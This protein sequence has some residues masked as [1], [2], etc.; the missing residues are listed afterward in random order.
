MI[1]LFSRSISIT[2]ILLILS[3]PV[4]AGAITILLFDRNFNTSNGR[5][6]SNFIST[7]ILIFWS[8]RSLYFNFTWVWR[9]KRNIFGNLRIIYAILGIG[10]L[11]LTG[12]ILSNSSI[13]IILHDSYYVVGH[14]HY[15]LSIAA[16]FSIIAR[17]IH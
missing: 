4:L 1:K 9:K 10:F 11:E 3:L 13:D 8:S 7:F 6:R 15:V 16:V 17:F 2:V 5:R 12:I 14:F